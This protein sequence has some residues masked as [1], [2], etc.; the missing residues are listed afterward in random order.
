MV[1]ATLS[2]VAAFALCVVLGWA[3]IPFLK[4][5]WPFLCLIALIVVWAVLEYVS[6]VE[7]AEESS[8]GRASR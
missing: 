4:L 2:R 5:A 1:A 3:S 8:E 7:R 6:A